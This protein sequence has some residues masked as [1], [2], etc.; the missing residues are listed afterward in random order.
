MD[1]L[2]HA[3][4]VGGRSIALRLGIGGRVDFHG[5][6]AKVYDPR[7]MRGLLQRDDITIAPEPRYEGHVFQWLAAL[8]EFHPPKAEIL[9]PDGTRL[10]PSNDYRVEPNPDILVN[11]GDLLVLDPVPEEYVLGEDVTEQ[12]KPRGKRAA[13]Q[14]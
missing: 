5:G 14:Q 8:D 4:L 6:M 10:G 7:L 11:P 9:M 1:L 3:Y 13:A 12:A 2:A